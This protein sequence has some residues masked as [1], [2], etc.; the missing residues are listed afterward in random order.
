VR[1]REF[2]T[3]LGGAAAAWPL[4]ARAQQAAM[5]V[6]GWLAN[7]SPQS[8]KAFVTAFRQGLGEAGFLEGRNVTIEYRWTEQQD[9]RLPAMAAD[10]VHRGV[11][12][13]ATGAGNQAALAAKSVTATIP[14]VFQIGGD[15]AALGLV[16]SLNRPGGNITGVTSLNVELGR[17]RL[18]VLHELLPSATVVAVLVNPA[19]PNA[20]EYQSN[21]VQAEANA[22]GLQLHVL[23][24]SHQLDFATVF[25][26]LGEIHAGGLVISPDP[27]FLDRSELLAALA[28]RQA[29]PTISPYREFAVAGGLMSYGGSVREISFV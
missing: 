7:A 28:S 5:P 29:V 19:N 24:A 27:F 4:A 14:I 22:F 12:V 25:A 11:S 26:K 2:I 23:R 16:A 9:D 20:A 1:R 15:P 21:N 10:L 8:F 17:K 6:I 18:E 3:L 13:I